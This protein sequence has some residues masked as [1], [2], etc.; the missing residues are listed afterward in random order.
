MVQT[1][2]I[3][4]ASVSCDF[5]WML[6]LLCVLFNSNVIVLVLILLYFILLVFLRSLIV[7]SFFLMREKGVEPDRRGAG[8]ELGG[9]V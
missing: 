8:E 7:G 1:K 3:E 4:Q 2:T 6:S 9:L 5:S